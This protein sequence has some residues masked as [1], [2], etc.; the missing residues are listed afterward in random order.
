[1]PYR[2]NRRFCRVAGSSDSRPVALLNTS[3]KASRKSVSLSMSRRLVIGQ[4]WSIWLFKRT[5]LIGSGCGASGESGDPTVASLQ[6]LDGG[7]LG[8]AAVQHSERL[9]H[10]ALYDGDKLLGL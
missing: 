5:R 7:I 2:H 6:D 10:L 1:M 9:G 4:R 8:Q 3:L